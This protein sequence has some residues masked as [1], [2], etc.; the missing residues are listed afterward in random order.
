MAELKGITLEFRQSYE[1]ADLPKQ[2]PSGIRLIRFDGCGRAQR[3]V[4]MLAAIWYACPK[5]I[6]KAYSAAVDAPTRKAYWW[7]TSIKSEQH[8]ASLRYRVIPVVGPK[9]NAR[10]VARRQDICLLFVLLFLATPGRN[11]V[12]N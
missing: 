11:S 12:V 8:G 5:R 4:G 10:R 2:C 7:D 3:W 9:E 1:I 6:G